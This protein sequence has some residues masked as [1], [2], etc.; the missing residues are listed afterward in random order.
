MTDQDLLAE[1]PPK[2]CNSWSVDEQVKVPPFLAYRENAM[3]AQWP[4]Y[5]LA[6]WTRH[7]GCLI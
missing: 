1:H 4:Q 7:I 3:N 2:N 6:A 5:E